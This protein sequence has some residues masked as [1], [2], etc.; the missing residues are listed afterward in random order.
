MNGNGCATLYVEGCQPEIVMFSALRA[1]REQ[2]RGDE[3]L[4]LISSGADVRDADENGSTLLHCAVKFGIEGKII[5]AAVDHGANVNA[6]DRDGATPLLVAA[7]SGNIHQARWL[8]KNGADPKIAD[9]HGMTPLHYFAQRMMGEAAR[10]CLRLGADVDA[11]NSEG[12]TPLLYIVAKTKMMGRSSSSS[13]CNFEAMLQILLS[14]GADPNAQDRDGKTAVMY[15]CEMKPNQKRYYGYFEP[16]MSI[17]KPDVTIADHN[18]DIALH[19]AVRQN[20]DN[21]ARWLIR[22]GAKVTKKD[23]A[24]VSPQDMM[25]NYLRRELEY[26]LSTQSGENAN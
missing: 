9:D 13:D 20:W 5:Q 7:R 15:L 4:A 11:R 16:F 25:S 23:N 6:R 24:G 22:A 14:R 8:F 12:R 26:E 1:Y 17:A 19:A 2:V 18:G 21:A 10:R 3:L